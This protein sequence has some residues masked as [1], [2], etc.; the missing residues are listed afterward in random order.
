VEFPEL[1]GSQER[2][3]LSF[4]IITSK[5]RFTVLAIVFQMDSKINV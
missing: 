2:T 4:L 3:P 5:F 1:G